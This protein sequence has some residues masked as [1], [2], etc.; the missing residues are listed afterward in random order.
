MSATVA[1]APTRGPETA[2][3]HA[4]AVRPDASPANPPPPPASAS[5]SGRREWMAPEL[6]RFLAYVFRYR[7]LLGLSIAAGIAKFILAYGPPILTGL[8]VDRV[9][10]GRA[11]D[12]SPLAQAHRVAFLWHVAEIAVI[13]LLAYA[14]ATFFRDFLTGKLGFRVIADLRQD[15]FDHLHRLS[16]HFYSKERT[17]SIVSRVITDISQASN[18]V[19]GGVVA[20]AMDLVSMLVGAAILFYLDWRL[21]LLALV[22]LPM[23]ALF[24]KFYNP[25][26]KQAG[27]L[28]QRSIGRLSGSVQERLAGI[29]LVQSSAAEGRESRRFRA[30]VEEHYDRVVQQKAL[31]A[32]VSTF[33]EFITRAGTMAVFVFGGYLAVTRGLTAGE[34]TAFAG[35]LAVMYFPI[36]R[37]SEVNVVYQTCMASLER[38]FK[39]F[40]I[41]PKILDK[42]DAWAE[43][44]GRGEVVF[45]AVRFS[46]SDDSDESRVRLKSEDD[47]EDE[48]GGS[49]HK[50]DIT[51]DVDVG[52]IPMQ[53]RRDRV[54]R[55]LR[56]QMRLERRRKDALRRGETPG[57]GEP[58][59]RK[60]VLDGLSFSVEAGERVALV[61]PSGSGKTTLVSLLPRLYD[62]SEGAILIDG[63][64][65]RDFKKDA[66]RRSIGIVQQ[67]S[68]LFS[69]TIREN[70]RYGR[71]GASDDQILDAAKAA[72][73]HS[74]ITEQEHGYDT[75][76]G[77]RGVNLSG[78]QRQR[79]SIARAILKDPRI[80]ILDEATSALDVESERLVQ[81]ALER[82]MKGRTCFII[83]HRLSTIRNADRIFVI[84][85]G[86]KVEEGTHDSLVADGGLY[87]RLA[88]Q[89]FAPTAE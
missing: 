60:W 19:N 12:G 80:L 53:E 3:T 24:L 21:T 27:V 35:S 9:V 50:R 23:N 37:F 7:L 52:A 68:F 62:V 5:A 74:F 18:L 6:R 47:E 77:E 71:P 11:A 88:R 61:G 81:Q 1:A 31:S 59:P 82:L 48:V 16:L 70:L 30:D 89:A 15:L 2:Q 75:P 8:I 49:A 84:D 25:R 65:L 58:A 14:A 28:V 64:D 17:G 40:D 66:L 46:Y 29:A 32:T 13:V 73:A 79:L 4:R 67:D 54:R 55:E 51:A 39:V 41:T 63:R 45:D 83:A 20:V 44:V 33:G 76:L 22:V 56:R 26:V 69:G 43:P 34:L 86:R 87:A 38:I 78:G 36:Q 57:L 72:N 42:P 85:R 10:T